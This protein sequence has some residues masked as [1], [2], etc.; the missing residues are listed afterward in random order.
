[1]S[2]KKSEGP[3]LY[4]YQPFSK[5]P[6]NNMQEMYTNKQEIE[7]PKEE[8]KLGGEN[9]KKISL[10]KKEEVPE[11]IP[12]EVSKLDNQQSISD[13]KQRPLFNRVKG[14]KEMDLKE[15]LDY[16]IHFP[17]VLPPVPCVFYTEDQ[18]YQ[19]Y[20]LKY[21]ND[22]ATIQF[23]DQTTKTIALSEIRDV[24]LIGIKK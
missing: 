11:P 9:K 6:S 17:K 20:L 3:L 22:Q 2:S 15:R 16:L 10:A 4:I 19:G 1:M 24:I 5:T 8:K 7:K 14:F 23:H 13:E 18:N 21:E 12:I